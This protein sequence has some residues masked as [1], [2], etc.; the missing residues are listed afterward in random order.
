MK[1]SLLLLAS[2]VMSIGAFAQWS[3]PV[4][5]ATVDMDDSGTASQFLYNVEAGGFFAGH[6]D[7]N[8]RASVAA[9]GDT[10]RMI[11]LYENLELPLLPCHLHRQ[12]QMAVCVLQRLRCHVG[13]CWQ[14]YWK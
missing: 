4:P 1:K 8:T 11:K 14:R 2:L 9:K 10:I 12:N 13:G 3:V 7:W 5:S 6:N